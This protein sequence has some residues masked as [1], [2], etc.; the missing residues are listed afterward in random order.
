MSGYNA[1]INADTSVAAAGRRWS[2]ILGMTTGYLAQRKFNDARATMDMSIRRNWGGV[3]FYLMAG[4]VYPEL[5]D[6]AR[7]SASR[8]EKAFGASFD[9]AP[10]TTR[11]WQLGLGEAMEGNRSIAERIGVAL[12]ERARKSGL[13][14]D[15]RLARSVRAFATLARGDTATALRELESLVAE[16]VP[17][18]DIVWDLAAPRGFERLTLARILLKKGDFRKALDVANVF[19]AAWPSVYLLYLPA[20]L[21]LR[22]DA[23]RAFPDAGLASQF[24]SRLAAIQGV[25]TIAGK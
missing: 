11:L 17:G 12:S 19:D 3:A 2:S 5:R 21:Q 10:N 7:A 4:L 1:V 20:S 6:A 8:D 23:A 22:I 25:Q 13:A 9:G 18:N 14:S 15:A 16:P 24:S